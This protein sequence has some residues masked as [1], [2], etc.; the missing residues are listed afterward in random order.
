MTKKDL[1][2]AIAAEM[3]IPKLLALKIVQR[4]FD[5]IVEALTK[6]GRIELRNFGI[7]EVKLRKPRKARNPRSG[8]T[9]QVP[10]KIVVRFKPGKEM[11]ADVRRSMMS[12]GR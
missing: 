9:V 2:S 8:E 6:E 10:E 11:Q 5:G 3:G 1:A 7:F 12:V 4:V